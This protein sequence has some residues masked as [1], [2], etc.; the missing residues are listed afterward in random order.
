MKAAVYRRYGTP[1]RISIEDV[2]TPS[3]REGEVLVQVVATSINLSDWEGLR[4]WPGYARFGGLFRPLR[5]ILG[6][7]IA[8]RVV[9]VGAGVTQ[10]RVGDAVFGDILSVL[11]GLAEF[12][13]A[14]ESEFELKP[15]GI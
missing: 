12:D 10:F 5:H 15:Q 1:E 13:A 7:D 9:A 6:S 14:P 8:G 2:P 3:P 11:G 4:G